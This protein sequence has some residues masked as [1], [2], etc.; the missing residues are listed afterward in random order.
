NARDA[1]EVGGTVAIRTANTRRGEPERPEHPPAGE[2]VVVTVADTGS[3]MSD[4]VLARV[5]EPFF[6]TKAV[7][8]GSGLGLA[9]VFGFAKQSGGGVS[10]SSE[11]G[12]GTAVSVFLPRA[13][14]APDAADAREAEAVADVSAAT[15][16]L[17]DDDAAV[18]SVAR[19]MLIGLGATVVEADGGEAA[20]EALRG[21]PD[22]SIVLADFAMP[23]MNGAELAR[24]VAQARPGLP[25]LML[26]GYA[27][28]EAI[29]D[30]PAD[31]VVQKPVTEDTLRRR[32]GAVLAGA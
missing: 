31:R 19:D 5:F 6:T 29:A 7:G 16:L 4:E 32:I 18:R 9:Q 20:L 22:V 24:R 12:R 8:K 17:V 30:V 15:V 14:A 28:L 23:G 21:R 25:F 2:H 13:E 26:T 3:G 1:L 11:P 10:I 27:D